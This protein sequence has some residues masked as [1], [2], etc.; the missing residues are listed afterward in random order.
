MTAKQILEA[1]EKKIQI[2]NSRNATCEVCGKVITQSEAQLAHRIPKS[3]MYLKRYG[4]EIIHHSKNLALVCGLECNS[5]VNI[6]G[7]P[8]AIEQLVIEIQAI[9]QL[10]YVNRLYSSGY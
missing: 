7:S 4:K 5:R 10:S 2:Y 1:N 3:K 8:L 9:I 6:N